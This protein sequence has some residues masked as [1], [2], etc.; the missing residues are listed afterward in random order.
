MCIIELKNVTKIYNKDDEKIIALKSI[1][2]KFEKGK[3]YAIMGNSGAGKSTLLHCMGLLDDITSGE[4]IIDG[5]SVLNLSDNDK[6]DIIR[7][8]IGFVFQEYYLNPNMKSYENVMLPLFLNK[9]TSIREKQKQA[10]DILKMLGLEDR[11]NHYPNE[12]SG[13]EQQRVAIARSLVNHPRIILADE[14]TGNLDQNNEK[15]IF[16]LLKKVSK[17]DKCVIVVTHNNLVK[18]YADF[19][20][21]I[22]NGE[23]YV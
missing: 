3:F 10:K 11:I 5:K 15:M 17:E 7:G 16:S 21:H 22:K 23:L 14:P 13:G 18:K 4:I 2:Y 12:L 8:K 20:V 6:S 1:S 9:D 19:I